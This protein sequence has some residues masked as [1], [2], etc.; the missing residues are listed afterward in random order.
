MGADALLLVHA[1]GDAHQGVVVEVREV[2]DARLAVEELADVAGE[3]QGGVVLDG[4]DG[5]LLDVLDREVEVEPVLAVIDVAVVLDLV[6]FVEFAGGVVHDHDIAALEVL[7]DVFVV[8]GLGSIGLRADGFPFLVVTGPLELLRRHA[9]AEGE[10]VVDLGE[11]VRLHLHQ[12]RQYG[13]IGLFGL[14]ALGLTDGLGVGVAK[15]QAVLAE[16]GGDLRAHSGGIVGGKGL[17]HDLGG[18]QAILRDEVRYAGELAAVT[19]RVREEPVDLPV[20]SRQGAGVDDA[21]EE[22]VRLLELVIEEDVVLREG[23]ASEVVLGDH[24]AA[25]NVQPGEKPAAAGGLLVR[26]AIG[27]DL[28]GE[29][30]VDHREVLRGG[31][32]R[33]DGGGVQGVAKGLVGRVALVALPADLLQEFG[34]NAALG[35]LGGELQAGQR[36][37]E[38]N[39]DTFHWRSILSLR[40]LMGSSFF[41]MIWL[42]SSFMRR[43]SFCHCTLASWSSCSK[44]SFFWLS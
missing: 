28:V 16:L 44:R 22:E 34:G 19:D 12:L 35:I 32:E 2:G 25:E 21:L 7:A 9:E 43:L 26:A 1:E 17:G 18:D 24:L 30:G 10:D 4:G 36:G 38:E 5:H 14:F 31:G 23:E 29:M 39:G 41:S 6:G 27:L 37:C 8:E 11:I 42:N 20:V 15:A 40:F 13:G 3:V 33:R